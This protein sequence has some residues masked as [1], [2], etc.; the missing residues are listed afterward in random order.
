MN[1]LP[2][3]EAPSCPETGRCHRLRSTNGTCRSPP[4]RGQKPRLRAP[5]LHRQRRRSAHQAPAHAQPESDTALP[6]PSPVC[7]T[8]AAAAQKAIAPGAW[9]TAG[10]RH[11]RT[12]V[13]LNEHDLVRTTT[14]PPC[15]LADGT[16]PECPGGRVE[17]CPSHA[18]QLAL[19]VATPPTTHRRQ[20]HRQRSTQAPAVADRRTILPTQQ[21][22]RAY[23]RKRAPLNTASAH[24]ARPHNSDEDAPVQH[25][26]AGSGIDGW[27]GTVD[28]RR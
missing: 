10:R 8:G 7:R 25:G 13:G 17:A 6:S 5:L 23:F 9:K 3:H 11:G 19:H 2:G 20:P 4:P 18:T 22:T 27:S 14:S 12:C 1:R 21:A 15:G 26:H 28:R 24:R 16:R